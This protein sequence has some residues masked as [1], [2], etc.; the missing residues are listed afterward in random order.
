METAATMLGTVGFLVVGLS[1]LVVGAP[2]WSLGFIN[3]SA[4]IA[5]SAMSVITAPYGARLIHD[6]R[7]DSV[8][9]YFG[10]YLLVVAIIILQQT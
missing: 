4:F 5:I 10:L 7:L 1:E 2:P 8:S 3:I 6:L 9:R